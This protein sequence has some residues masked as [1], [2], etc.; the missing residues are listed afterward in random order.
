MKNIVISTGGTGGHVT[1]A[2]VIYQHLSKGN[3]VYI[4]TE[5]RGIKYLNKNSFKHKLINIKKYNNDILSLIPFV[6]SFVSS[7]YQSYLFL[8]KKKITTVISVGGY[9]SIPVCLAAKLLNIKIYLLEPNQVLGRSNKFLLKY[10]R[11]IF[12]YNKIIKNYPKKFYNKIVLI[13]PLLRK[14]IYFTKQVYESKSRI[15]KLL[16]IGGSQGALKFDEIFK[17]SLSK[18]SKEFKLKVFHQAN[19]TNTNSLQTF[20]KRNRINYE[21]FSFKENIYNTIKNCNFALTRSG[22][23]TI[24]ELVFL[25]VP[26]LAIP[27]PFAKDDHQFFNAFNYVKK[28]FCW[29]KKE[30]EINTEFLYKFLRDLIT[31]KNLINSKKKKMI[32]FNKR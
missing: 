28:N 4:I 12:T 7:F 15:F 22:A 10:C 29:L 8:N 21:V 6:I 20:Y 24:N 2:K 11:K 27:Y 1:P 3:K 32:K 17:E 23:S 25:T 13:K 16:I 9:M 19:K 18:L 31:K 14:E 5:S 30:N 26:F